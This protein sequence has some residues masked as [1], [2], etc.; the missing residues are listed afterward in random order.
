VVT[1]A[2]DPEDDRMVQEAVEDGGC[3]GNIADEFTPIFNGSVGGHHGGFGFVSAHDDLKM[4]DG[5]LGTKRYSPD[6]GG[7]C[8]MPISSMI[9]SSHLGYMAM[10]RSRLS[11][12]SS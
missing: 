6:L 2:L 3:S 1:S 9:S 8:L 11:N 12:R 7:S 5:A 10:I 4:S